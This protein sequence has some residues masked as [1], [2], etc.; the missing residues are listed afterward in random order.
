MSYLFI[1]YGALVATW[2]IIGVIGY[3]G[4]R[5]HRAGWRRY[6]DELEAKLG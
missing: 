3:L 6:L 2:I 4:D 5:H 1:L